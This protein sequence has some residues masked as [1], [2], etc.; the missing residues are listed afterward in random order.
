MQSVT[1]FLPGEVR[2][3][4]AQIPVPGDGEVL[5]KVLLAGMC[6]TD[7]HI[8]QGHFTVP[9]PRILGHE[10][11]GVVQATGPGVSPDWTGK[12][13]GVMPARFCGTCS[14]CRQ[15]QPQLC[16]NFECLGNTHDGGFAGYTIVRVEQLVPLDG[17]PLLDAVWL[18]PLACVLQALEQLGG[19]DTP[20]PVLVSGAGVLGR[21]MVQVL[22]AWG[23]QVAVVDPNPDRVDAAQAMGAQAGWVVP[24]TGPVSDIA[25][26][27]QAWAGGSIAAL[28]DTTG[29]PVSIERL[30]DWAGPRARVLLFGVSSPSAHITISPQKLFTRELTILA[31]SGMTPASF[32]AAYTLLC[33]CQ[34]DLS[35]LSAPPVS[36]EELPDYLL[37]KRSP[38]GLKVIVSPDSVGQDQPH[39]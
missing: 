7:R 27:L 31:S 33:S 23:K 20:D 30:L 14:M 15:G 9:S 4:R 18:E 38:N 26:A 29:Q 17:L 19:R 39:D 6:T 16:Q 25:S 3:T 24:R 34:L 32:T 1:Y 10:L 21:L 28:I 35:A 12:T 11:A 5:L 36:L 2:L 37:G 8:V 13:C 22:A